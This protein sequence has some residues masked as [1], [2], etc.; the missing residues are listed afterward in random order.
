MN[1]NYKKFFGIGVVAIAL[2]LTLTPAKV[3][4]MRVQKYLVCHNGNS[5]CLPPAGIAAHLREHDESKHY[6]CT[7]TTTPCE[8]VPKTKDKKDCGCGPIQIGV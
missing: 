7:V 6:T 1:N 3:N 2:S 4:S 5:L 8:D